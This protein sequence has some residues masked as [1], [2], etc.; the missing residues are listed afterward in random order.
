[1]L[2]GFKFAQNYH[3]RGTADEFEPTTET[4]QSFIAL[5][6]ENAASGA[7]PVA[8]ELPTKYTLPDI[9]DFSAALNWAV[10]AFG[11]NAAHG[12]M[13]DLKLCYFLEDIYFQL[14]EIEEKLG[15]L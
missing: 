6:E 14:F 4:W 10:G 13:Y 11:P 2:K 12:G 8:I 1:M 9:Y 3:G 7:E 15:L 5:L